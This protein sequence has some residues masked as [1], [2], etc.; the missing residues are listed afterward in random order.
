MHLYI[1]LVLCAT[2][3]LTGCVRVMDSRLN[4]LN[5]SDQSTSAPLS[6]TTDRPPLVPINRETR[7][8]DNRSSIQKVTSIAVEKLPNGAIVRATGVTRIQGQFNAQL[9]PISNEFGILTLLFLIEEIAG[10]EKSSVSSHQITV[11]RILKF[12]ELENI[13]TI[14]IQSATNQQSKSR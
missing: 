6:G 11:A 7:I 14:R 4:P 13:H 2:I 12:A 10:T 3:S 5:W 9:I 8:I 1:P